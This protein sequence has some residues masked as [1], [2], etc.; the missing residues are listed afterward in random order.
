MGQAK[1]NLQKAQEQLGYTHLVSDYDGVV[2]SWSVEVGQVVAM[3]QTVVTIARPDI[4]EAVFDI[5][6]DLVGRF[7]PDARFTVSLLADEAI[8][9]GAV[10]REI[11]PQSDPST[12]TRRLRLT[13]DNPPSA[14][15]LGTTVR[16]AL[17]ESGAPRIEVPETAILD[18]DGKSAVWLV[19]PEGKVVLRAVTLASRDGSA[20]VVGAGLSA[21]DRVVVAGVNSLSEGQAVKL[22]EAEGS[23]P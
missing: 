5:P 3:A 10:V 22:T 19:R 1:A 6:D 13:L 21:G 18:R 15:R 11:A 7:P 8:T 9:A 12:R 2:A 4:R 14:F 23:T 17:T 20:A 16:T